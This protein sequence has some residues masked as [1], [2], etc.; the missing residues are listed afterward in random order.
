MLIDGHNDLPSMLRKVSGYSVDGL[1]E[2]RIDTH[3][4]LVRLSRG[5]IGGQFWSVWVPSYLAEPNA[6]VATLEQI[7]AVYR[8]VDR[9][10][11]KLG[12]AFTADEA[13][14]QFE[15]GRVASLIGIEGGHS[16]AGSLGTL[17]MFARL[18]VRYITLT[19]NDDTEWAASATGLHPHSGL[20]VHGEAI[21]REM[22]RIGLIVDLSHTAESTQLE[23]IGVT[24]AP[25]IFSHSS[26]RRLTDHPRNVSDVVLSALVGNGGVLQLTFVPEFV[27]AQ[28]AEWDAERRA[29]CLQLEI[30][31]D[32]E[33]YVLGTKPLFPSAPKPAETHVDTLARNVRDLRSKESPISEQQRRLLASWYASNPMPAATLQQVADH[34]DAAREQLGIAHLG[35]SGDYDGSR[36]F[37]EGLENVSS[38]PRLFGELMR[39][40]W[41]ESD[42]AKLAGENILRVM[43]EVEDLATEPMWPSGGDFHHERIDHA[44]G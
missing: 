17:R 16:I 28:V 10:P 41:S 32:N 15:R 4:D 36:V 37:P 31:P 13:V 20:D 35:V 23:T 43:R 3:T 14:A 42:L 9:Y 5:R 6:V 33:E 39:R 22:N 1:D 29:R 30:E 21:I 27:S 19:H 18:G 34:F 2:E 11:D 40:R 24:E 26:L 7:D 8:L 44:S 12:I 38:Y 25:V